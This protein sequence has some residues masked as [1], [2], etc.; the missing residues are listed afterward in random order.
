MH[1]KL[2]IFIAWALI[3]AVVQAIGDSCA[4]GE[5]QKTVQLKLNEATAYPKVPNEAR[6]TGVYRVDKDD[7]YDEDDDVTAGVKAKWESGKLTIGTKGAYVLKFLVPKDGGNKTVRLPVFVS[8]ES[9][10]ASSLIGAAGNSVD[11]NALRNAF[12]VEPNEFK[13]L[14]LTLAK[15]WGSVSGDKNHKDYVAYFDHSPISTCSSIAKILRDSAT[16]LQKPNV[17]ISAARDTMKARFQ[18]L[19]AAG[20][21]E[22]SRINPVKRDWQPFLTRLESDVETRIKT[23]YADREQDKDFLQLVLT[24]MA[25]GFDQL[26]DE[27]RGTNVG[28]T[29]TGAGMAG[30]G[31]DGSFSDDPCCRRR[32]R[33]R[34]SSLLW[35]R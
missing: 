2:A 8:D 4:A 26:A 15:S 10:V 13:N 29:A 12:K 19:Y 23:K 6:L 24:E 25:D 5:A 31:G 9:P 34:C 35:G 32:R 7:S 11:V 30:S 22:F 14:V 21:N 18:Q 1:R 16:D 20:E 27:F 28:N 33:C 17:T 3:L